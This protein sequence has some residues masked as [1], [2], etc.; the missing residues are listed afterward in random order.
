MSSQTSIYEFIKKLTVELKL[1]SNGSK[2]KN[3]WNLVPSY[4]NMFSRIDSCMPVSK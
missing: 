1:S 3:D 2:R 4:K